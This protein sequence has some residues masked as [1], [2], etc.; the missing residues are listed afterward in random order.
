MAPLIYH[1]VPDANSLLYNLYSQANRGIHIDSMIDCV[2]D[3]I[4]TKINAN[5]TNNTTNTEDDIT[6]A[7]QIACPVIT[8]ML[9]LKIRP[10]PAGLLFQ[11]IFP[12][13]DPTNFVGFATTSIHWQEVLESVV[14]DYVNGLT[15]VISTDKDSFTYEINNGTYYIISFCSSSC[16]C[17]R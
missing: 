12:A 15:C 6:T 1:N 9:E 10:G 8:D 4:A 14:P 2:E 7:I 3:T 11:P 5:A 17:C 13:H 16:C